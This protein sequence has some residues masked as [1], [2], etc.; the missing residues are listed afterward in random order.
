MAPKNTKVACTYIFRRLMSLRGGMSAIKFIDS[1]GH[2]F[3]YKFAFRDAQRLSCYFILNYFRWWNRTKSCSTCLLIFCIKSIYH[4]CKPLIIIKSCHSPDRDLWAR[5]HWERVSELKTQK[6]VQMWCILSEPVGMSIIII[7]AAIPR[8]NSSSARC[9][10]L[11]TRLWMNDV[12]VSLL[13]CQ[14][15]TAAEQQQCATCFLHVYFPSVI[16]DNV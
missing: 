6:H 16:P 3:K 11:R 10:L 4:I 8:R 5:R 1:C 9:S 13:C 7:I 15:E 12:S 2:C 14:W